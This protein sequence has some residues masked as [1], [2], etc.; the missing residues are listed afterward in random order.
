[1]AGVA[2]RKAFP[3][4]QRSPYDIATRPPL[5]HESSPAVTSGRPYGRKTVTFQ[6]KSNGHKH[7]EIF[8]LEKLQGPYGDETRQKTTY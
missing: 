8:T 3:G 6:N 7:G 4:L 1:M 2:P 5:H